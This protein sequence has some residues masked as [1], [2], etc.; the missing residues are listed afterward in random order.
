M[1]RSSAP[2]V[3]IV[4]ATY[5][6]PHLLRFAL[7]SVVAQTIEDWEA[8]VVGDA[9]GAETA[10]AVAAIGDD[11]IRYIDLPVN[12]GEQSGPNNVGIARSA[13]PFVAFLNQDD[14]WFPDH[15]EIGLATIEARAA[16]FALGPNINILPGGSM[17]TGEPSLVIDGLANKGRYDPGYI[18]GSYP[19]SGWVVRRESLVALG[20]WR[21]AE[22][23]RVEPSQDLLSRAH[24]QKMR[25]WC[26]GVASTIEVTSGLR[27]GSYLDTSVTEHEWLAERIG[28]PGL[29]PLL[30]SRDPRTTAAGSDRVAAHMTTGAWLW[31]RAL[32]LFPRWAPTPRVVHKTVVNRLKPGQYLARLREV[33]GLSP[34]RPLGDTPRELRYAEVLNRCD[35]P[36]GE[37][38]HLGVDGSGARFLAD[39]WSP[40]ERGFTWNDGSEAVIAVRPVGVSGPATLDLT[41]VGYIDELTPVQR[42]RV[43]VDGRKVGQWHLDHPDEETVSIPLE[44]SRSAPI[45]IHLDLLDARMYPSDQRMLAAGVVRM[46]LRHADPG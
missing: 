8:V 32:R 4:I 35:L 41:L 7:Q 25:M 11:R 28:D 30:L 36:V 37:T 44:V 2:R 46:A 31:R 42:V 22:E 23:I 21:S 16:D 9:A 26:T 39:G 38:V 5:G 43:S 27:P 12:F 6:R 18:D 10:A 14:L 13:A 45:L 20:G 29:R 3:S 34:R 40:S 15:L 19:P 1:S 24:R 33:R 17:A